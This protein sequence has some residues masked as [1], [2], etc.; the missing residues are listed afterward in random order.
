MSVSKI[1]FKV[2]NKELEFQYTCNMS[3]QKQVECLSVE[4]VMTKTQF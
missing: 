3:Q 2:N 1:V 4:F